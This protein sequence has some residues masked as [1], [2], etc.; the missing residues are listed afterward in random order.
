[1]S[2]QASLWT[3]Q[4]ILGSWASDLKCLILD[5]RI[6]QS[7]CKMTLISMIFSFYFLRWRWISHLCR[8]SALSE[9]NSDLICCVCEV[10]FHVP[11]LG[12]TPRNS[13]LGI[14]L[15]YG[16]WIVTPEANVVSSLLF[17]PKP[18]VNHISLTPCTPGPPDHTEHSQQLEGPEPTAAPVK[19]EALGHRTA[20]RNF[21][22]SRGSHD[23][24]V[25]NH[26]LLLLSTV[27][28][29]WESGAHD[30]IAMTRFA[31]Q[32]HRVCM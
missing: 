15:H 16:T 28:V 22:L 1:M 13:H 7:T 12:I 25:R 32:G 29:I 31:I 10:Y 19:V 2:N 23:M 27:V 3:M 11:G 14:G 6:P 5:S 4:I 18:A 26:L 24:C 21:S 20:E 8:L 9:N 17:F 30:T